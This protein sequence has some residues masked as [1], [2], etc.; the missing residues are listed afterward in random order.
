MHS[1]TPN[2]N[3]S[4]HT[5]MMLVLWNWLNKMSLELERSLSRYSSRWRKTSHF[6]WSYTM[7]KLKAATKLKAVILAKEDTLVLLFCRDVKC[8]DCYLW[9][10]ARGHL[11]CNSTR[12]V[13]LHLFPRDSWSSTLLHCP[14]RISGLCD[15]WVPIQALGPAISTLEAWAMMFHSCLRT[16]L[17]LCPPRHPCLWVA[18]SEAA[19]PL[20]ATPLKGTTGAGHPGQSCKWC[21]LDA[22]KP[23]LWEGSFPNASHSDY[24][25]AL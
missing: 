7:T 18:R 5:R 24:Y 4:S 20:G 23:R 21:H 12:C 17:E 13:A 10:R 14:S 16:I 2:Y 25:F 6:G 19:E 9:F 11:E 8:D 3:S 22:C 1:R 15:Q